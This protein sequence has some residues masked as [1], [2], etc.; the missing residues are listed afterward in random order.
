MGKYLLEVDIKS[1]P[2]SLNQLLSKGWKFRHFNF[3]K[4]KNE[5]KAK[6]SGQ[7]PAI[8]LKTFKLSIHRFATRQLDIDNFVAS[9]KP[10][11]D[12]L[13]LA[14]VIH[15]DNWTL[16]NDLEVWQT[17]VKGKSNQLTR[18]RVEGKLEEKI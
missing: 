12:G 11:I 6:V 18:I 7:V 16:L 3:L 17:K 15:D 9:L 13:V 10:I 1:V 5:I 4:I 8:P 14:G 2:P